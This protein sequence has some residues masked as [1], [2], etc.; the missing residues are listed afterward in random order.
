M[1]IW[2]ILNTAFQIS[3]ELRDCP[4]TRAGEKV[5]HMEKDE[6]GCLLYIIY[7]KF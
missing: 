4:I 5:I 7:K 2:N 1:E 3:G 6:V